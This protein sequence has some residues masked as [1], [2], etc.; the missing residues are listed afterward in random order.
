MN[1]LQGCRRDSPG[2]KVEMRYLGNFKH[3]VPSMVT[4]G[5]G[6]KDAETARQA[7]K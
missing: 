1:S 7:G 2:K 4:Q 6:K 3:R 5:T